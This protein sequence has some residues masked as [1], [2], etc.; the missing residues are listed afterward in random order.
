M[1]SIPMIVED[2]FE[3][4][5][6]RNGDCIYIEKME[7]SI[8]NRILTTATEHSRKILWRAYRGDQYFGKSQ[9]D[10]KSQRTEFGEKST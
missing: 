7:I 8:G 4:L 6:V 9:I 5:D 1:V 2:R 10:L 3:N